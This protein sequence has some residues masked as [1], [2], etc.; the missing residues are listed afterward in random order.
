MY[1]HKGTLNTCDNFDTIKIGWLG[2]IW[3]THFINDLDVNKNENSIIEL[4]IENVSKIEYELRATFWEWLV[5]P[6]LITFQG[7]KSTKEFTDEK[8]CSFK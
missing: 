4:S 1:L 5:C 6:G 2:F 8:E 7:L 3:L